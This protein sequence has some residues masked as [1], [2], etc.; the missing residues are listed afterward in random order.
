MCCLIAEIIMFVLGIIGVS[1]GTVALT[2]KRVATGTPA[3]VAGALLL[4]PLPVYILANLVAGV[5][6]MGQG[7]NPDPNLAAAAGVVS[8]IAVGVTA[9]CFLAAIV[10]CAVT[11]QP[12]RRKPP[13]PGDHD[14]P[15]EPGD[16]PPQPP[17]DDRIR[18]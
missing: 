14:E 17:P 12:V 5:S 13:I 7:P 4:I 1:R 2:R 11:A 3:R 18:E 16:R 9:L 10:I 6:L 15:F 8:G